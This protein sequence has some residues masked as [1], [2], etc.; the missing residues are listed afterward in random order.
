VAGPSEHR[1]G[2]L[3]KRRIFLL[4][5]AG[6]SAAAALTWF[7]QARLLVA[8]ANR[9]SGGSVRAASAE[10][11]LTSGI[12]F[13]GVTVR[14]REFRGQAAEVFLRGPA[15]K[16]LSGRPELDELRIVSPRIELPAAGGEG[17]GGFPA[18]LPVLRL[19]LISG[20]SIEAAGKI[21][22]GINSRFS[23]TEKGVEILSFSGNY[24]GLSA[25]LSGTYSASGAAAGGLLDYPPA[26]A[27]ARFNYALKGE[28]HFFA[29]KGG[30]AG[31]PAEF[32]GELENGKWK[33]VLS[34]KDALPLNALRPSFKPVA[35][36]AAVIS[37][38]GRGYS[39]GTAS[40]AGKFSVDERP[41]SAAG[42]T[43]SFSRGRAGLRGAYSYEGASGSFE[44]SAA[45]LVPDGKLGDIS[46]KAALLLK[47]LVPLGAFHE[48]LQPFRLS[49]AAFSASGRGLSPGAASGSGKFSIAEKP[50]SAGEGTF[51]FRP[52]AAALRAAYASRGVTG[53][54]EAAAEDGALSGKFL[55]AGGGE[56][57]FADGG[58]FSVREAT[59]SC[60]LGGTAEA[61]SFDCEGEAGESSAGGFSA[62][63]A[64]FS[65]AVTAGTADKFKFRLS[66]QG[67]SR[68]KTRLDSVLFKAGGSLLDNDFSVNTVYGGS[69]AGLEGSSSLKNGVWTGELK[70]VSFSL[71]PDWRFCSPASLSY[72]RAGGLAV[73]GF[74]L[75]A[76]AGRIGF[77]GVF[78]NSFPEEFHAA[79]TGFELSELGKAGLTSLSPGGLMNASA[80]YPSDKTGAGTFSL[81]A[82]G[83]EL[84]GMQLGSAEAGGTFAP[85][86]ARL[87]GVRWNIYGGEASASGWVSSAGGETG[88]DF[89]VKASSINIAPLAALLPQ[90]SAG[91]VW[92]DGESRLL[93]SAGTLTSSGEMNLFAPRLGLAPLGL[94]LDNVRVRFRAG[95]LSSA[96]IS[97]S[98][99]SDGG[100][101]IAEGPVSA[102]G[103][104]LRIKASD[105]PFT[106]QSGL[107]GIA[108]AD[109]LL[110][111]SWS[112]S[113]LSGT[114]NLGETRF[115]M[116]KW[117]KY[118][119]PKGR[120]RFYEAMS[121]DL[122]IAAERNAWYRANINSVEVKG[123]LLLKK[124]H[125]RQLVP[126]GTLEA[127]KGYYVY[128]GNTFT[129]SSGRATFTGENPPDPEI[130]VAAVSEERGRPLKVYFNASGKS[131]NPVIAL[132]SDPPME[133]RDIISFLVTGKPLYEIY[134]PRNGASRES[135]GDSVAAQNLAAGYLSHQAAST[136]GRKLDIDV[137]N[138][139]VTAEKQADIT[140][141]RYIT[142]DLFVSYGQVLGQGGEKRVSAEYSITKHWSLEGK[143]SSD[144]RY[145]A[146][147]LFKFGI[148]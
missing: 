148:R 87:T 60:S 16:L 81:S 129:L 103:P 142:R 106:H 49:S 35:I 127:L 7:A 146:D 115:E 78:R 46:W 80:D 3:K 12:H 62:D 68:H 32:S 71:V 28:R 54:L 140:L 52:G 139:K 116:D 122:N 132:S 110:A 44:A 85:G 42:G 88:A 125:Y 98:G 74:C 59:A 86:I 104:S 147:L 94:R 33:A 55:A 111:G 53:S 145:V 119:S 120:S 14:T 66:L 4:F 135:S 72:S 101:I 57:S 47:D 51:S 124:D 63:G 144:G 15:L 23:S 136:L 8:V 39:P 83:L 112:Q 9:F 36:R 64:R 58:G 130:A 41:G 34:F 29:A 40:L 92:A 19:A 128:L 38:S 82:G 99:R 61:P 17:Q 114:V 67:L 75:S 26:K 73:S 134:A 137:I 45:H 143:N 90:V 79:V 70:S 13:Y 37:A 121:M 117:D 48:S 133:Q 22:S 95:S 1:G 113:E 102:S 56:Y 126:L 108:S 107:S 31:A 77:S 84:K 18:R 2:F 123:S 91:E 27:G 11:T 20:G 141:G 50:G 131:R 93:L 30:I 118:E 109:L 138:L 65:A 96:L 89:S 5:A 105:L 25:A 21:V 69:E 24:S 6:L 76:G 10:G 100:I 97:A 43:F